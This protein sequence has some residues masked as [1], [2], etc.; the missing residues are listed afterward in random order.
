MNCAII[1]CRFPCYAKESLKSFGF[2][3]IELPAWD[4]LDTPV[5]AHPDMLMYIAG[6]KI[7]THEKYFNVAKKEFETIRSLGYGL[8]LSS[9]DITGKYPYDILFNCIE[10]GE[11]IFCKESNASSHVISYAKDNEKII[12]KYF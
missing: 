1:D 3:I 12:A 10:I 4:V 7:I 11:F 6:K 2:K 8:I 5:S 9:E